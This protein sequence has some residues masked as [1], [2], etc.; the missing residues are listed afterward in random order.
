MSTNAKI[1]SYAACVTGQYDDIAQFI[2]WL[3]EDCSEMSNYGTLDD[4]VTVNSDC[5][6]LEFNGLCSVNLTNYI[7]E[8]SDFINQ[9]RELRLIFE[10]WTVLPIFD[11]QEHCLI[12]CGSVVVNSDIDYY[13]YYLDDYYDEDIVYDSPSD[14]DVCALIRLNDDNAT[15]F[16]L[17]DFDSNNQVSFGGYNDWGHF[18]NPEAAYKAYIVNNAVQPPKKTRI[19]L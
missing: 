4:V 8:T 11:I 9:T 10:L 2:Q 16:S 3:K 5:V 13:Q 7:V 12:V 1:P 19:S 18:L 17:D 15:D 6:F 14:A